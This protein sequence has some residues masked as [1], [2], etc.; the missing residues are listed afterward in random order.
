ML[1][2]ELQWNLMPDIDA[3][4]Q[5]REKEKVVLVEWWQQRFLPVGNKGNLVYQSTYLV[6]FI[7][8]QSSLGFAEK[9]SKERE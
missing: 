1:P 9:N 4:K 5:L 6:F 7:T 8:P 3:F 2:N